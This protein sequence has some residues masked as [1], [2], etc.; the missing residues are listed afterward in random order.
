MSS[1]KIDGDHPSWLVL[2]EIAGDCLDNQRLVVGAAFL[3]HIRYLL[4]IISNSHIVWA[5]GQSEVGITH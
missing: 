3:F 5:V 4:P 2:S 1:Y